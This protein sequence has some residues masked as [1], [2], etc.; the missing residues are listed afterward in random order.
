[1][2]FRARGGEKMS[3]ENDERVNGKP[4]IFTCPDCNGTLWEFKDG[5]LP[6]FRCRVGHAYSPDTMRDGYNDSVEGALWSAVRILEETASF[7]RRLSADA[8]LRGDELSAHRFLDAATGREDQAGMIREMLM[9]QG[10]REESISDI[11]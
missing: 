5:E 3:E 9:S 1:V 2:N 11:A 6:R 7:E 10:G 8:H 4:S